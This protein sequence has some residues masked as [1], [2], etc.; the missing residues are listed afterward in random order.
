MKK[1]VK[2]D[3]VWCSK[4]F[5]IEYA[6][7]VYL[8]GEA[9]ELVDYLF[10]ENEY[11]DVVKSYWLPDMENYKLLKV[12]TRFESPEYLKEKIKI[13]ENEMDGIIDSIAYSS[14]LLKV[15]EDKRY[16]LPKE[17]LTPFKYAYISAK[18]DRTISEEE[19]VAALVW[20][21]NNEIF[22]P[23]HFVRNLQGKLVFRD[24]KYS[25]LGVALWSLSKLNHTSVIILFNEWINT[26]ICALEKEKH[27]D[28]TIISNNIQ[29]KLVEL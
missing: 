23:S 9:V 2:T 18:T 16:P 20:A 21:A 14:L 25:T 4:Y 5:V 19:A 10:W 6:D 22:W 28:A 8:E 29:E 7:T 13:I 26:V 15:C 11:L 27:L 3:V 1:A 24:Y 12:L 17:R